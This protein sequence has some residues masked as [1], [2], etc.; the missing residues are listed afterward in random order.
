MDR[1]TKKGEPRVKKLE[2]RLENDGF[3]T[4]KMRNKIEMMGWKRVMELKRWIETERQ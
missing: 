3:L 2:S 1:R 4:G